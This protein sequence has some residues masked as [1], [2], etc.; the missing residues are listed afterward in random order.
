[1]VLACFDRQW[2]S[3]GSCGGLAW[4]MMAGMDLSLTHVTAVLAG[5]AIIACDLM[6]GCKGRF[7]LRLAASVALAGSAALLITAARAFG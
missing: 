3:F 7:F 6:V 5:L 4:N 1:M 2:A